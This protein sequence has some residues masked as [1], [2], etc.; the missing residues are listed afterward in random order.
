MKAVLSHLAATLLVVVATSLPADANVQRNLT[1]TE[2]AYIAPSRYLK[3]N[4]H[5]KKSDNEVWAELVQASAAFEESFVAGQYRAADGC[6]NGHND[7][8]KQV[9][10]C[11]AS[12]QQDR[13]SVNCCSGELGRNL[14]CS[15]PGC[16]KV[17]TFVDAEQHCKSKGMR[18]CSFEE[19]DS[20]ACCNKG[21]GFNND[22]GWTSTSCGPPPPTPNPTP[23]PTPK[24]SPKPSP[25]PT[26]TNGTLNTFGN[27]DRSVASSSM[28]TLGLMFEVKAEKDVGITSLSMLTAVEQEKWAEV[29][30]R[31]GSYEGK[32]KGSDGWDRVYAKKMQLRGP[33]VP[34]TIPFNKPIYIKKGDTVSFYLVTL[35]KVKSLDSD[36]KEG[37]EIAADSAITLYAGA[38]LDNGRW[39]NG[40]NNGN[41]CVY[42]ARS[43]EGSIDYIA[44]IKVTDAPTVQPTPDPNKKMPS[45]LT[46]R[47]EQWL[48]GHNSRRKKYHEAYGEKYVP[49]AWS[50]AL[51]DM[52]QEY[53]DEL[54]SVCGPTVHAQDRGG[55]GENLASN[56][57]FDRGAGSWGELKPV[58]LVMTRYVEREQDWAPPNNWH[59]M[60][61]LWR[62]TKYVGCADSVGNLPNGAV[63]RYQVCRYARA[64]NCDVSR[65]DDGSKRWWDKAWLADSSGCT[66]FCPPD[67]C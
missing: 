67:G 52:A 65:Y 43:F 58:D 7:N 54:A 15:R 13:V 8:N 9:D 51:R 12:E 17:R 64:G 3:R 63:C 32:T 11:L 61:V 55:Y 14:K 38:A 20:G 10:T 59:F 26:T 16:K 62:A 22:I 6:V 5:K 34:T 35:A 48:D 37:K 29:W 28:N 18:L 40:C 19:M 56:S 50:E 44:D 31:A 47:E 45:G 36:V 4:K 23:N 46:L 66:P 33:S 2:S 24:P 1:A 49:L 53:A 42:S 39:E 57:G 27:G 41:Q 25:K 30:T 60:Q 21:C